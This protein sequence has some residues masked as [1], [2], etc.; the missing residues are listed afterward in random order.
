MSHMKRT[1]LSWVKPLFADVRSSF[2]SIA[3]ASI[4][5]AGGGS[6]LLVVDNIWNA[7]I[8]A[9]MSSTPV[10]ASIA[11]AL[12][13]IVYTYLKTSHIQ[14]S[15]QAPQ[16]AP[17]SVTKYFTIG[18]YKW[19]TKIYDDWFGVDKYP[20]C[21]THDLQFIFGTNGKHCPGTEKEKCNSIL[22]ERD[23]F[24]VYESAKSII[25]NKIRNGEY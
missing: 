13:V 6:L 10:W 12:V 1:L 18:D 3:V 20:F 14:A 23:E 24:K 22:R 17:K 4:V 15:E 9:M 8:S 21:K 7:L 16:E 19:K 11:L 5:V 2:V 25:E